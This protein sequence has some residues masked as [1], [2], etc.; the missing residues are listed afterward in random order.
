MIECEG[1]V[2]A[3]KPVSESARRGGSGSQGFRA[4]A[5]LVAPRV[6]APGEV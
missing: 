4:P 3:R 5:G 6:G 2:R 1:F